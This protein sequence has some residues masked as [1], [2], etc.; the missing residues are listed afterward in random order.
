MLCDFPKG[1][2]VRKQNS[3]E[4]KEVWKHLVK[5]KDIKENHFQLLLFFNFREWKNSERFRDTHVWSFYIKEGQSV[6]LEG[7]I[8]KLFFQIL[9][10]KFLCN[11]VH[12]LFLD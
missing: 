2:A 6:L 8:E 1:S 5:V 12:L 11:H 10:Q 9:E 3:H 4:G 7:L